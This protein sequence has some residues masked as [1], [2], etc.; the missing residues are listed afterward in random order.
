MLQWLAAVIECN[1]KERS[2]MKMDHSQAASHGFFVNLNAVLLKMCEP[3]LDP[4]SGKAW[5]K[6]DAGYAVCLLEKSACI[7]CT[8]P[9]IVICCCRVC[10]TVLVL[11]VVSQCTTTVMNLSGLGFG[12]LNRPDHGVNIGAITSSP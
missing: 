7:C 6:I 2:K 12:P 11:N 4:L 5:G 3:F 8:C 1:A 9:A 10:H